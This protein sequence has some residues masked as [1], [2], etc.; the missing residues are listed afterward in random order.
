MTL[1]KLFIR[2]HAR[3]NMVFYL[4]LCEYSTKHLAEFSSWRCK[5][6]HKWMIFVELSFN[7]NSY[8][9]SLWKYVF[10]CVHKRIKYKR[11]WW[12]LLQLPK[13]VF[14]FTRQYT[15]TTFH[16]RQIKGA[17]FLQITTCPAYQWVADLFTLCRGCQ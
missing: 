4:N 17:K 3:T 10:S 1:G 11:L 12:H 5:Y 13:I 2:T 9:M 8:E 16:K 14:F 15:I 6:I 7:I